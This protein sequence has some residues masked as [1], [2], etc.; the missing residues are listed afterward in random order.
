MRSNCRDRV[1]AALK[2][3]QFRLITKDFAGDRQPN[4]RGWIACPCPFHEDRNPSF[5]INVLTG[6]WKC[7]A[8][9]G[10]GDSF[11]LH[12]RL[13]G[14]TGFRATLE[15]L[16]EELGLGDGH[17]CAVAK[18]VLAPKS[19]KRESP[20]AG[21]FTPDDAQN[22]WR[23]A[24]EEAK[25]SFASREKQRTEAF[26]Q[27]RELG[28]VL[29]MQLHGV[30][31]ERVASQHDSTRFWARNHYHLVVPLYDVETATIVNLQARRTDTRESGGPKTRF[32][33]GGKVSGTVFANDRG[34]DVLRGE[35]R[36]APAVLGEGLTDFLSLA[37]SMPG[38]IAVFAVPGISL[39]AGVI[40]PWAEGRRVYLLFDNDDAGERHVM[41]AVR[42]IRRVGGSPYRIL[43]P[44]SVKDACDVLRCAGVDR[45]RDFFQNR[46]SA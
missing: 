2:Q 23:F 44:P 32:P 20:P 4:G 15:S 16:K 34:L 21:A 42:A 19:V 46:M 22:V 24:Y 17:K 8:G 11:D 38:H 26:L 40:K 39:S 28:S 27:N 37:C 10:S 6:R 12:Q 36:T 41:P 9:C 1:L 5:G 30:V 43:W 14:L 7:Q 25:A 31:T 18:P 13:R 33:R 29:P 45:F 3:D 35:D